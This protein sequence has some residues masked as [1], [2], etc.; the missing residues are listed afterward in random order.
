MSSRPERAGFSFARFLRAGSR[1]GGIVARSRPH[2]ACRQAPQSL[3]GARH[4]VPVLGFFG[5][6]R[7]AAAFAVERGSHRPISSSLVFAF[8]CREPHSPEWRFS[9]PSPRRSGDSRS[10]HTPLRFIPTTLLFT[11][12]FSSSAFLSVLCVSALSF[13]L[14]PFLHLLYLLN[15]LNIR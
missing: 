2:P 11:L 1:S 3:V 8:P 14:F 4:A 5:V 6:R 7:R 12:V 13:L 10:R 15:F 9:P